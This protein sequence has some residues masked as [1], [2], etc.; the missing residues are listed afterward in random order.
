MFRYG[1][2]PGI[3]PGR[4]G[5]AL[6]DL[7]GRTAPGTGAD[8]GSSTPIPLPTTLPGLPTPPPPTGEGATDSPVLNLP[9]GDLDLSS[10]GPGLSNALVV[11]A[12]HTTTGHPLTVFGP[13]TG[14]YAAGL[15]GVRPI[16]WQ[17]RPTFQQVV[18]F[19]SHR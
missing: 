17:N 19:R 16:D 15:V 11:G 6:P 3:H 12:N 18:D 14:Y 7:N 4:R 5:V 10:V 2:R 8:A 1:G 13:Q 9:F